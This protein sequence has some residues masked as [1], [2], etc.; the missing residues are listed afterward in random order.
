MNNDLEDK[1]IDVI[2]TR[3]KKL[4]YTK[5][6]F[7]ECLKYIFVAFKTDDEGIELL[8]FLNN[9]NDW[10][11]DKVILWCYYHRQFKKGISDHDYNKIDEDESKFVDEVMEVYNNYNE[12]KT[13]YSEDELMTA[14]FLFDFAIDIVKSDEQRYFNKEFVSENRN[15]SSPINL[16]FKEKEKIYNIM[17]RG[18][19]YPDKPEMTKEDMELAK[20]FTG[21]L[22]FAGA[23]IKSH[24]EYRAEH[25][26]ALKA[27]YWN[28]QYDG[29][30]KIEKNNDL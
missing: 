24:N 6:D 29:L 2:R 9:R 19:V 13:E 22:Y 25:H 28:T 8:D 14:D 1:I 15:F 4:G 23:V 16:V 7:V 26:I 30:V 17:V 3:F 12:T 21:E 27:D 5:N 18:F 10:N 11:K 20:S